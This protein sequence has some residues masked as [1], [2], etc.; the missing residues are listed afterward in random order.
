M[1]RAKAWRLNLPTIPQIRNLTKAEIK[2]KMSKIRDTNW[3]FFLFGHIIKEHNIG[4]RRNTKTACHVKIME[5]KENLA[6]FF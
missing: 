6:Q 5:N 1:C 4:Q 2:K 3:G